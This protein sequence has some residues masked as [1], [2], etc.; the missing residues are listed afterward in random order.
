MNARSIG[1]LELVADG[2]SFTEAPRWHDGSLWFSD[3]SAQRVYR[4]SPGK[5]PTVVCRVPG[6]PSGLGFLPDG[7]LVVVSMI[8]RRLLRLKDGALTLHADL[9]H[10]CDADL[11]DMEI[12]ADGVA[13]VGN[14]G[15]EFISDQPL[16]PTRLVRV[17]PDGAARSVGDEL[18]FPNGMAFAD[19]GKTL[20]VA[21]SFASRISAFAIG[22]DGALSERR[23]WAQ[24]G[25]EPEV[26]SLAAALAAPGPVPDGIALDAEG[27]LWVA[28]AGGGALRVAQGGEVLERVSVTDRSVFAVALGGEDLRTL[29]LCVAPPPLTADSEKERMGS[30]LAC[31]VEVPGLPGRR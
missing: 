4:V 24:L 28:D 5:T 13:Y 17:E 20:L 27:A 10:I 19:G 21:E 7:D 30:I 31:Q 2:L 16:L 1:D 6:A 23:I 8:D 18:T 29:Y 14:L 22:V 3:I 12:T 15:S 11:N 25:P 9:S 26:P